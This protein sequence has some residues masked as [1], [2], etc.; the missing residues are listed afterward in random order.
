MPIASYGMESYV[1]S[2]IS[3]VHGY[4]KTTAVAKSRWQHVATKPSTRGTHPP[5]HLKHVSSASSSCMLARISL[6]SR[7]GGRVVG[8]KMSSCRE[9]NGRGSTGGS[10]VAV[11]FL[12]TKIIYFTS[13]YT[14]LITDCLQT[15]E[16]KINYVKYNV[17]FA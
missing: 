1:T 10:T 8:D 6:A 5:I 7:T 16:L 15:C 13:T 12:L 9:I 2:S 11:I 3:G 4:G 14:V 17:L